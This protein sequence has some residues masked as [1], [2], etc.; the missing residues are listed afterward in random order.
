MYGLSQL[1]NPYKVEALALITSKVLCAGLKIQM[2]VPVRG[3]RAILLY[4]GHSRSI[5]A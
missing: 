2:P 1:V 5:F 4:D 3:I